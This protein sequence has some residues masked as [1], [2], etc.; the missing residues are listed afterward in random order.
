MPNLILLKN[1]AILLCS[2]YTD[3]CNKYIIFVIANTAF[4]WKWQ[5]MG[6]YNILFTVD[7]SYVRIVL[8]AFEK[9]MSTTCTSV[10]RHCISMS[11]V[12]SMA[13]WIRLLQS[14]LRCFDFV[15]LSEIISSLHSYIFA[16]ADERLCR[17]RI[18]RRIQSL[19][20]RSIKIAAFCANY[21]L[22][23]RLSEFNIACTNSSTY[24][25]YIVRT[26]IDAT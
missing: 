23:H 17:T 11:N 15:Q 3:I 5:L 20:W 10:N 22:D 12:T 9:R 2:I 16:I 25:T 24:G 19:M 6:W 21:M 8:Y 1:K 14:Y 13:F 26:C 4:N 7:A 18:F